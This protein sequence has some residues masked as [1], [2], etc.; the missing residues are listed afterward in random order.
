MTPLA[1]AD[2]ILAR[3]KDHP[4]RLLVAIAGPPASGK[5][6][7]AADLAQ[8]L[9]PVSMVVSMDGFH[10]DDAVLTARGDLPRKGAPHTYDFKGL[11]HCI[12]RIRAG[13]EVA[14]PVFDRA[15]ELSRACAA[16]VEDR[17]RIIIVEGNYLLLSRAPW[18]ELRA[19]FD[20]SVLVTAPEAVLTD[21]LAARW[22]IYG[23]PDGADWIQ[24]NDLPNTRLV[25]TESSGAD[26]VITN[27]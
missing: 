20:L 21:R 3:G 13:E 4:G 10:L 25:L 26:L 7:L 11:A 24:T 12:G 18:S 17:H 1:L 8:V 23:R 9:G 6:T 16:V 22:R 5:T 19:L 2:M 27:A 15:L 14:I